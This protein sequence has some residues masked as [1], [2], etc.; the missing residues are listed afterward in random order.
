M[1]YRAGVFGVF[2][3]LFVTSSKLQ[4]E[5]VP[6]S[7]VH[8]PTDL[9]NEKSIIGIQT[10]KS[11][12]KRKSAAPPSQHVC[13][14]KTYKYNNINH[15]IGIQTQP[16]NFSISKRGFKYKSLRSIVLTLKNPDQFISSQDLPSGTTDLP[17]PHYM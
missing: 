9:N 12:A 7:R 6:L 3:N 11:P 13:L 8:D 1:V 10:C 16:V 5:N 17:F 4:R 14:G 15:I 2:S